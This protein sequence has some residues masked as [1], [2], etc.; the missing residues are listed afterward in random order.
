[1]PAQIQFNTKNIIKQMDTIAEKRMFAATQRV[2]T[3]VLKTLSGERS[4]RE[5]T[6]P[7]TAV[8]Y[9]ASAP[10]E[11]PAVMTSQLR[12]SV[13]DIVFEKNKTVYGQ[14]GT[15]LE[16]GLFLEYGTIQIKP[17]PWL[18][19]SFKASADDVKRI[20]FERWW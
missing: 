17:R 7:G 11:P 6:V 16:K 19:P 8:K 10:G 20:L 1:M 15:P 3:E 2:R 13:T 5:Y 14:V 18:E 4:G 12:E 9:T